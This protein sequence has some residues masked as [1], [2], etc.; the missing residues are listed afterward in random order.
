VDG[1]PHRRAHQ[2]VADFEVGVVLVPVRAHAGLARLE[3]HLVQVQYQRIAQEGAHRLDD[4]RRERHGADEG[5]MAIHRAELQILQRLGGRLPIAI[6]SD[7]AQEPLSLQPLHLRPDGG[8]LPALKNSGTA[9]EAV[10]AEL[11]D[12]VRVQC[13]LVP[14][15]AG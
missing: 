7:V 4:L 6:G 15:P 8:R 3:E 1:G 5:A 10:L 2:R 13:H 11:L 9:N 12:L 14:L